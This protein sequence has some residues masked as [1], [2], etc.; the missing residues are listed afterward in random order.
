MPDLNLKSEKLREE[1]KGIVDF[2]LN[3]VGIDGFRL[4]AVLW[5]ES[6]GIADSS[7]SVSLNAAT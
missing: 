6:T 3:D 7:C 4:D 1:I 5:Y 2:W